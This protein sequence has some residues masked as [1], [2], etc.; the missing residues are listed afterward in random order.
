[1]TTEQSAQALECCPFCGSAAASGDGFSPAESIMA[2]LLAELDALRE[3]ARD[4][5]RYRWISQFY[6]PAGER[7]DDWDEMDTAVLIGGQVLN[8]AIDA[9]LVALHPS[10]GAGGGE[11]RG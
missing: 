4:A 8:A 7:D 1:M 10:K 3:D 6:V 2:A 11:T 5:A 9:K